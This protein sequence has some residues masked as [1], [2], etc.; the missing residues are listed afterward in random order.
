MNRYHDSS[1]FQLIGLKSDQARHG[2]LIIMEV[3]V[4][5]MPR[6]VEFHEEGPREGFQIERVSYPLARRAELI[7][8]LAASGLVQIQVGSFVNPKAVPAMADTAELFALIRKRPG[9]RYTALWLNE[10]GFTRARATPQVDL[11]GKLMFYASN[12]FSLANN[13]CSAEEMRAR[14]IDWIARYDECG[15]P[16]EQ[17]YVMTAFGC[18]YQGEVPIAAVLE[19]VQFLVD[20]CRAQERDVPRICLADTVGWATPEVVKQRIGAIRE[21]WP[22]IGVGLHLHDTRGAGAANFYAALQM[23][24]RH[25]DVSVGGLGGCPFARHHNAHGAG[26][27]CT[28]DMVFMCHEMGIETGIDLDALIEAARLAEEIIGRTLNGRILHSGSLT[29]YRRQ[30]AG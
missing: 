22:E 3:P 6:S 9:V 16:V 29:A 11:D 14:Q 17:A 23:G 13:G 19:S 2:L 21:R 15:I 20:L 1:H 5:S 28:E 27:I 10:Q 25:F 30:A 7:D 12:A 8:L 4:S 26:N 18:N 24:V